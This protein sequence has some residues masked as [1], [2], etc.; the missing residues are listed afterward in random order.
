MGRA[1]RAL[2]KGF[3]QKKTHHLPSSPP[4]CTQRI[5]GQNDAGQVSYKSRRFAL[6]IY[7]EGLREGEQKVRAYDRAVGRVCLLLG[8]R[9]FV[10][11]RI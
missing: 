10:I 3:D 4:F 5:H 9:L 2:I 11:G 6:N 8:E 7:S 1:K